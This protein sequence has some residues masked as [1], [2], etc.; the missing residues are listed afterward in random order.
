[1]STDQLQQHLEAVVRPTWNFYGKLCRQKDHFLNAVVGLAA[2]AGE[3]LDIHKKVWFH[4][5]KDLDNQRQELLSEHGDVIYYWL[6]SLDLHG[7]TVE[8][9]LDYNRK[10]L[11]SRHPELGQVT[12]RF[13][14][15]AIKG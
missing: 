8:E 1:M 2:E 3:L 5:K 6:Q 12:E 15:E 14:P 9:V 4:T 10:K 7:F 13:G 11:A